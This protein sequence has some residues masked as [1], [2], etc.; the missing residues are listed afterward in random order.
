M[1][2]PSTIAL[3]VIRCVGTTFSPDGASAGTSTREEVKQRS[4]RLSTSDASSTSSSY[5]QL[6]AIPKFSPSSGS[7][8]CFGSPCCCIY[9]HHV[10]LHYV[11][12]TTLRE[13]ACLLSV[14]VAAS[15]YSWRPLKPIDLDFQTMNLPIFVLDAERVPSILVAPLDLE[16]YT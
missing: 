11:N 3:F 9:R 15:D 8:V 12:D 13:Q 2:Y 16:T 5:I 14:Y 7:S 10:V 4:C 6:P 1:P